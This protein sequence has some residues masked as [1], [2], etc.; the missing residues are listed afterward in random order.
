M[1]IGVGTCETVQLVAS[2]TRQYSVPYVSIL[3]D[4]CT[5]SYFAENDSPFWIPLGPSTLFLAEAVDQLLRIERVR[6]A[7]V[8]S[9]GHSG[10]KT[11]ISLVTSTFYNT[12]LL[13]NS[14]VGNCRS[15]TSGLF[16][17]VS[18]LQ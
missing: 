16:S 1:I 10:M 18:C 13:V 4:G 15:T 8:L 14:S 17:R 11:E 9:G 12:I 2:I 6:S 7:L 5:I 3:R